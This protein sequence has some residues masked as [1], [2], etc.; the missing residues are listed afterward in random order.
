MSTPR[1]PHALSDLNRCRDLVAMGEAFRS[2][3][4]GR[5]SVDDLYRAALVQS[6]SA[7]DHYVHGVVIDRAV[8]MI[9]GRLKETGS[10]SVR[11]GLSIEAVRE[12]ACAGSDYE[13]E[14]VARKHAA[15]AL[16]RETLQRPEAIQ[17][18]LGFV[19]SS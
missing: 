16:V 12:I 6:V 14:V 10:S 7:L 9:C 13:R 17:N 1:L 19:G 11:V 8:A 15:A 3:V 18:A 4:V 5:V 2:L